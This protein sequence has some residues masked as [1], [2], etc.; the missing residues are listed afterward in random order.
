MSRPRLPLFASDRVVAAM[1]AATAALRATEALEVSLPDDQD[2]L[3]KQHLHRAAQHLRAAVS[4][5]RLSGR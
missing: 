3:R 5:L 2:A 4:E 1:E